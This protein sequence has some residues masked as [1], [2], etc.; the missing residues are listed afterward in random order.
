MERECRCTYAKQYKNHSHCCP[1][2]RVSAGN[3]RF[4]DCRYCYAQGC[5]PAWR[6]GALFLGLLSLLADLYRCH[7]FVWQAGRSLWPETDLADGSADLSYRFRS[8]RFC[9][10]DGTAGFLS[11]VAR[12]G[13]RSYSTTCLDDSR[14]YLCLCERECEID[15]RSGGAVG[16]LKCRRSF[17]GWL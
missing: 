14:R 13:G 8:L 2:A 12:V 5:E 9:A 16:R 10:D 6:N 7:A 17:A 15:R 3:T 11:W 4:D 1:A